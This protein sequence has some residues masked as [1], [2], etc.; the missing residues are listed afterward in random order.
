MRI[1]ETSLEVL[2]LISKLPEKQ[3]T[4]KELVFFYQD[5]KGFESN[6]VSIRLSGLIKGQ[7]LAKKKDVYLIGER[8]KQALEELSRG[9]LTILPDG[10]PT[11]KTPKKK[12]SLEEIIPIPFEKEE[13]I[14]SNAQNLATLAG[15]VLDENQLYRD[16]LKKLL[17]TIADMLGAQIT[18]TNEDK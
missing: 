2:K 11:I 13:N 6:K 8:G 4:R 12:K 16:Y 18:Y 1:G 3:I 7:F 17:H 10:L 9:V 15:H 5:H 14:S